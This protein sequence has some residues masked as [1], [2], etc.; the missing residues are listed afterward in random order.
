MLDEYQRLVDANERL[1]E[2][3]ERASS[4]QSVAELREWLD[5]KAPKSIYGEGDLFTTIS[6]LNQDDI[7]RFLLPEAGMP[8]EEVVNELTGF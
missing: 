3:K 1:K 7:T 6:D 2:C 8:T 5:K 4:R